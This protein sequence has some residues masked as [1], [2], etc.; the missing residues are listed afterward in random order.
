MSSDL[1]VK[2]NV[3][4]SGFTSMGVKASARYFGDVTSLKQLKES[5]KFAQK[6]EL[7]ILV[8]GGGSNLLFVGNFDG[9]I[10]KNTVLGIE[11][12][13]ENDESILLKI[14]AGENWNKLVEYAVSKGYGG[15]ENLSL[16]PGTVGAAPIQNI[17]AYGAELKDTFETLEALNIDSG[18]LQS[19]DKNQCKFGYRDSIFKKELKGKVIILSVTLRLSKKPKL[20]FEYSALRERLGEKGI[21]NPSIADISTAVIEVRQSKLPDPEKIGNTGSFFKN[22]EI[23]A[24]E[25]EKLKLEYPTIPGYHISDTITKVPAG[26]L[27]EQAGW[28]GKRFGDAGVHEKQALVLVNHGK[29][30]GEELWKLAQNVQAS[31]VEKFNIRLIPEVNIIH[32]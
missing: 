5:L 9:L 28:K 8:L 30:T 16:I 32:S 31:V 17:G 15:I 2:E 24:S 23:E 27:I 7:K 14:G 4:L 18:E 19:F 25:F 22:P 21:Q 3:D 6:K 12:L 1:I 10:I 20:N 29:A 11:V 26:W 13:E